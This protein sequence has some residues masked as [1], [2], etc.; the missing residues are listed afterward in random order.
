MVA[1]RCAILKNDSIEIGY[2]LKDKTV[3]LYFT[4]KHHCDSLEIHLL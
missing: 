1:N 2:S 3:T 4:L